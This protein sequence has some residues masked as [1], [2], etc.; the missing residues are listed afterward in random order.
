MRRG[1]L[2]HLRRRG[3][4]PRPAPDPAPVAGRDGALPAPRLPA[5]EARYRALVE[6]IP[7]VTYIDAA[8]R[9]SSSLYMSPQVQEILGYPPE[10][11]L[12]DPDLWIKL[13]HPEDR[14]RVITEHL[15]TNES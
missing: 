9:T 2:Q 4:R 8:D 12:T 1:A 3:P 5:I 14:E 10:E 15:R 13:L 7:A 11:W 6:H